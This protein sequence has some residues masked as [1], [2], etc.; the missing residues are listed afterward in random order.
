MAKPHVFREPVVQPPDQS[1]RLIPLTKGQVAIV[2]AAD[3]DWLN[4]WNWTAMWSSDTKSYYAYRKDGERSILMHRVIIGEHHK[5]TDHKNRNTLDNRRENIRPCSS[6]EN[7]ANRGLQ[8]NN[9]SG[10][11]GVSWSASAQ[12]FMAMISVNGSGIYLGLFATAQE[13]ALAYNAAATK[14]YGEFAS[15]NHVTNGQH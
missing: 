14:Y 9:H 13:A 11:R 2:D 6:S 15:L 1:I 8:K 4:Q 7:L 10:Y 5:E 3:F 12:K